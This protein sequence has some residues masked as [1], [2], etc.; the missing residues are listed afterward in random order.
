MGTDYLNKALQLSLD[1]LEVEGRLKGQERVLSEIIPPKEGKG[2]RFKLEGLGDRE[3]IKMD[4]NSYLG[5]YLH[6]ALERAEHEASARYGVSPGAV[7]FIDGTTQVHRQLEKAL[8]DFHGKEDC[9]LFSSAYGA[10]CGTFASLVTEKTAV[11]SDELNHNCIINAIRISRV[12][13]ERKF[14]YK[15]LNYGQ[16]RE[17]LLGASKAGAERV[18]IV[19]DGVFSM[20]GDHA[21]LKVIE[22]IAS[23]YNQ[24]FKEGVITLVDDSHGVAAYGATGRGTPEVTGASPDILVSTLGKGL[25]ADGGYVAADGVIVKY[26]RETS[27]FY[28][29]SNSITP[30]TAGAALKAMEILQSSEGTALLAKLRSN[31]KLFVDGVK[32]LGL[33]T[34]VGGH[35]IVP[36][37]VR[38]TAKAKKMVKSLFERNVLAVGLTYPVVPKGEEELRF[39]VSAVHTESDINY[40]LEAIKKNETPAK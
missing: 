14:I 1:Q 29:Y 26:L 18:I 23:E 20:R 32:Q 4:S 10:M 3:F 7:R 16:I 12:T 6:K 36:V 17:L 8:A 35:P 31:T 13:P 19:T 5:L 33:E 21:D 38:S 30:G 9:I 2:Y 15:H 40:V 27:P 22:E 24:K 37:L 28:V 11:I 34:I 25:G 39:Q